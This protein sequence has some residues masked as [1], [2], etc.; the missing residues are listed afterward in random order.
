[1][2]FQKNYLVIDEK[3]SEFWMCKFTEKEFEEMQIWSPWIE[4]INSIRQNKT[5]II[6]EYIF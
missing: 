4:N 6:S 2:M 5:L 3:N 1:M